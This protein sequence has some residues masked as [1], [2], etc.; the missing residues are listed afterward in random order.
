MHL[1]GENILSDSETKFILVG[2]KQVLIRRQKMYMEKRGETKLNI[3]NYLLF[4]NLYELWYWFNT[5]V[6]LNWMVGREQRNQ[7]PH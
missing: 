1:Y 5:T 4:P 3:S 6:L 7:I 2:R